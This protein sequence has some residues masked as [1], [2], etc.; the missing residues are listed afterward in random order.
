MNYS[1]ILDDLII[2]AKNSD[3]VRCV[4]LTGSA[5]TG[6]QHPL[7]DRDI[8]LYVR[9]TESLEQDDSW[10]EK[11][12]TI[13]AV[14]KLENENDQPTRLIYYSGGKLD[15]T[16]IDVAEKHNNYDRPF[17]VLLD[18]DEISSSFI[19]SALILQNPDQE[20][21]NECVNWANAAALMLAKAIV[22]NEPWSVKIR[23]ADLK[24]E[25]LRVIEWDHIIRYESTKDVRYLG[26]RMRQWMDED[27]QK[28]LDEC[29]ASFNLNDSRRALLISHLLFSEIASRVAIL[30][31]LMNF[32]NRP[33]RDEITRILNYHSCHQT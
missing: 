14:E 11:L 22:R 32:D 6:N 5:V 28:R 21:F 20:I 17:K 27:I 33:V 19:Q 7:S 24:A 15:F 1:K 4:V 2:W 3:N 8:E 9:N 10:W 16:L 12:G 25:L 29:W 23:D 31:G 18:K 30:S 26:T 13:L